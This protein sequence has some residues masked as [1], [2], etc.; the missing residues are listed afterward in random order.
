MLEPEEGK[1][2]KWIIDPN[3]SKYTLGTQLILN[4]LVDQEYRFK[5]PQDYFVQVKRMEALKDEAEAENLI[6]TFGTD[7]VDELELHIEWQEVMF[8]EDSKD[9]YEDDEFYESA[10]LDKVIKAKKLIKQQASAMNKLPQDDPKRKAFIDNVKQINQKYKELLAKQDKKIS[11]TGR[12][13]ELD[14]GRGDMD[15]IKG[16]IK[17]RANE[18]GFSEREEAAEVIGGI[19]DEYMISLESLKDYIDE[20]ESDLH[21]NKLNEATDLYDRNGI[22]ITR[23]AGG[24]G[25]GLM[26]QINIGGKHI[27][28]PADEFN[29]FIRALASI[30]DDVRDMKLQQ[31]RD[32]YEQSET[33]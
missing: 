30:K 2:F 24:R 29:N 22:Q 1:E 21:E 27:V 9:D 18:S 11:D 26:L 28:V 14:E 32:R 3:F 7:L 17:D 15:T 5:D 16:I 20:G 13:Q 19:A 10:D 6:N 25:R 33:K 31:P 12:N 23:F 4:T 8:P